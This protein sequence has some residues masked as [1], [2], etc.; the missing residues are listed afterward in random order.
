VAEVVVGSVHDLTLDLAA[1]VAFDRASVR[2]APEAEARVAAGR[3]RFEHYLEHRGG[4]VYGATT[5]PGSRAGGLLTPERAAAQGATLGGFMTVRAGTG[6]DPLPERCVRL[7]LLARLSN[8]L[9][10]SG[11]LRPGTVRALAGLIADPPLVPVQGVASSG[12]VVALSWLMAPLADLPLGVGEAMALI[13]GSP[14]ATGTGCDV[15]LTFARRLVVAEHLFAFSVAAA[16]CRWEHFDPRL[17]DRWVDPYY[18]QALTRFGE[19]LGPAPATQLDHQAPTSWRVIPNVLASGLQALD[20]VSAAAQ[21]GLQSLKDNPTFLVDETGPDRDLVASSGGYLDLRAARAVDRVTAVLVDLCVLA[22]RQVGRFLDGAGL[23]LPPLLAAP[24][25]RVGME[26]LAWCLTEPLAAAR[27][28]ATTTTLDAAVHDPAGNQSDIPGLAFLA[29]GKFLTA[30]RA[31]DD[32]LA[33]LAVT[34]RLAGDLA[35]QPPAPTALCQDLLGPVAR[36]TGTDRVGVVGLPLRAVRDRLR[37]VADELGT[38]EFAR[39]T[40]GAGTP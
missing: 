37:E 2:L 16:G 26:Y 4:Y 7:A 25:D 33:V 15:A 11:K 27:A 24:G 38:G 9:T 10:G 5:A 35:P 40:A 36:Q 34:A 13:N 22:S 28:A 14:F 8:A 31:A 21:V 12:E 30:A 32:C 39:L 17:A 29:Y 6:G 23:G 19:L 1:R 3:D 18:R 20:E